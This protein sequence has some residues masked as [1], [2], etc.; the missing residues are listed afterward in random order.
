MPIVTTRRANRHT[1][2]VAQAECPEQNASGACR[3]NATV[4]YRRR[5]LSMQLRRST[6]TFIFH[7]NVGSS[8][9]PITRDPGWA[10]FTL[11]ALTGSFVPARPC[12]VRQRRAVAGAATRVPDRPAG[13][14]SMRRTVRNLVL[15]PVAAADRPGQQNATI[16]LAKKAL[17]WPPTLTFST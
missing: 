9:I 10:F 5:S 3:A 1:T 15:P 8:R 13:G 7:S 6:G 4:C 12:A 16:N 17:K 11:R 14:A 2:I